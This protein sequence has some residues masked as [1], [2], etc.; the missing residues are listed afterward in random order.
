MR[1]YTRT[2]E[3][4]DLK[5]AMRVLAFTDDDMTDIFRLLAALLHL[6]NLKYKST[7]VQHI[8][9]TEIADAACAGRVAGLLGVQRSALA[10]ALT[11]RTIVVQGERV[12]SSVGREQ[13]L[14]ARDAFVKAIYGRI[15]IM[16][17][18]KINS[19]IY[20]PDVQAAQGASA[21]GRA[22][23]AGRVSI[24]VLDIFGFENFETNSFEQLC[25]NY[26]NESLQQFFVKHIFKVRLITH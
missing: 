3:F 24:G 12:V 7:T 5:A 16:V 4:T 13:A 17:V 15:F 25:I 9:A 1:I 10:D 18:N 11:R 26:A 14:E 6:G 22:P 19:V 20:R 2:Q 21:A 23:R 8:E